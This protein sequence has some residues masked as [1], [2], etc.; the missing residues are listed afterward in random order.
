LADIYHISSVNP[1]HRFDGEFSFAI[2]IQW[3]P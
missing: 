2:L 1:K 3:K